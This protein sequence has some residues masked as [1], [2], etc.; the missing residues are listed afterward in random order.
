MRAVVV[1]REAVA[2]GGRMQIVQMCGDLGGAEADVIIGELIV[3]A[4]HD[5]LAIAREERGTWGGRLR[6]IAGEPPDGLRRIGR[7][8]DPCRIFLSRH[9]VEG[10]WVT[11]ADTAEIAIALVLI[12]ACFARGEI[13][14]FLRVW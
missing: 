4:A 8:E 2:L 11:A 7:I 10:R 12:P 5:R 9:L 1:A 13:G 14:V 3:D 6:R